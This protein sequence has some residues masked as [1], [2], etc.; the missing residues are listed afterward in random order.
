MEQ[1]SKVMW[2]T[3]A[4]FGLSMRLYTRRFFRVDN[5]FLNLMVF[6]VASGPAAYSYANYFLSSAEVDAA[7]IN[8]KRESTH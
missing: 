5:N 7:A 8:N 6:A 1:P 3:A 2:G 4:I